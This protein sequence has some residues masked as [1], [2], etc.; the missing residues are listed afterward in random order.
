[1][2]RKLVA[3]ALAALA[4]TGLGLT[5]VT[6]EETLRSHMEMPAGAEGSGS[7]AAFEAAAQRM[8]QAMAIPYTGNTD[9]DFVRGMI[10]HHEAAVE[11]AE[12]ELLHGT[13][14][15]IRALAEAIIAA[16]QKE[17]AEMKAW[18]AANAP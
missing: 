9:V 5:R 2:N 15:E 14:P 18:L 11:M 6:A 10:P 12:I 3:A 7:T 13:N 1:M 17:I 16:Q 8:H 4:L